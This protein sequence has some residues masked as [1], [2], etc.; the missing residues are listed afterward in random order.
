MDIMR[1]SDVTRVS[2]IRQE[3]AGRG[4]FTSGFLL[5]YIITAPA[6]TLPHQPYFFAYPS[7]LLPFIPP[8]IRS[9]TASTSR[10]FSL[11]VLKAF[12]PHC[13]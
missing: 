5:V 12:L 11:D 13:W 9:A 6:G 7:P 8:N 4:M 2:L 10:D 3:I 1:N